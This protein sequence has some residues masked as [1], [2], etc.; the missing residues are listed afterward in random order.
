MIQ[1]QSKDAFWGVVR[2]CLTTF[3]QK[4]PMDA[5]K[6]CVDLRLQVESP[7]AGMS[8]EMIYHDEPFDVACDL[9]NN[10]LELAIYRA[11]YDAILARH[12]W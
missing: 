10:P 4:D 1:S 8:D 5:D 2:D 3:H 6:L 12:N 11:P 7:P 9:A